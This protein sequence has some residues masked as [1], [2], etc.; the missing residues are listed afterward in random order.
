MSR[1]DELRLIKKRCSV[2]AFDMH[3]E[4]TKDG[5]ERGLWFWLKDESK[6]HEEQYMKWIEGATELFIKLMDGLP[7]VKLPKEASTTF[8][9]SMM[10]SSEFR[11]LLR[12]KVEEAAL[13]EWD[14][15]E[16]IHK[17]MG[18]ELDKMKPKPKPKTR[19]K[20]KK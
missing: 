14:E 20:L 3:L 10:L 16:K 18:K 4:L 6:F 1:L 8:H 7:G 11:A 13:I 17:A 2:T 15:L 9:A 12:A 19:K 5:R